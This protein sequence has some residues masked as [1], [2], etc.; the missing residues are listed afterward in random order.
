MP[1]IKHIAIAT[2][3]AD[4]TAKFFQ[5]VF[6]L[7]RLRTTDHDTH[8]GHILTDGYINLAILDYK[9][10]SAAGAELGTSYSGIHHIGIEVEDI[11]D[12]AV[13]MTASGHSP[14]EDINEAFGINPETASH[15]FKWQAP[16]GVM[17]DISASGWDTGSG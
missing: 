12:T 4:G 14:R 8:Y 13:K 9:T 2:Q 1:R 7:K 3:D 11:E 5:D 15:E 16:D 10:P 17:L 6:G